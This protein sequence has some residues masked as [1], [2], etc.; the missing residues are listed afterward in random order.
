MTV[1]LGLNIFHADSAA[2]I[3]IGHKLAFAIEEE[4]L[5][6]KKHWAGIPFEAITVGLE[7]CGLK[8]SDVDYIALNFNRWAN[9]DK[10]SLYFL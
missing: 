2:C 3:F 6:R 8:F 5:N 10:K 9:I 1:T 4:R 7:N